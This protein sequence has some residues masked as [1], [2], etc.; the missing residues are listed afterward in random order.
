MSDIK[1]DLF[2]TQNI[3]YSL[4]SL[5]TLPGCQVPFPSKIAEKSL[6]IFYA[7]FLFAS[8]AFSTFFV[9][10]FVFLHPLLFLLH[11]LSV[12]VFY[13]SNS[14]NAIHNFIQQRVIHI[15]HQVFHTLFFLL[16]QQQFHFST[17]F[18]KRRNVILP[19]FNF[20]ILFYIMLHF[21]TLVKMMFP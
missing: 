11:T 13:T 3:E 4:Y 18:T 17:F 14:H 16:Y 7:V 5:W 19:S 21:P 20:M 1:P 2:P 15:I 12:F 8:A 10:P 9:S 6:S